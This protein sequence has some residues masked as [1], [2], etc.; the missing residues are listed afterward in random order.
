[1]D[2]SQAQEVADQHSLGKIYWVEKLAL[3]TGKPI[4]VGYVMIEG[5]QVLFCK[6]PSR[7]SDFYLCNQFRQ[8]ES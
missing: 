5:R 4:E 2:R 6:K 7:Q 3:N 1:M 8:L